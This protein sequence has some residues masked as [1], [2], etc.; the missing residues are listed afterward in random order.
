MRLIAYD[1]STDSMEDYIRISGSLAGD[2]LQ[3]FVEGVV[4]YFSDEYLRKPNEEDLYNMW[5]NMGYYL[6]NGIYPRWA[7]FIP[8]ISLPQNK[9]EG[10]FAKKQESMQKD[11]ERA[12]GV[13]QTRFAIIRNPTL[14]RDV[15]MLGKIMI[16]LHYY[17]QYDR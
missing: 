14:T 10:L 16:A 7:A 13:I 17:A 2:C 3:H 8:T 1:T 6:T 4:S 11:V 12:F 15:S 5:Y 9:K